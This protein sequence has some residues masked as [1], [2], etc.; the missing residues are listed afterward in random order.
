MNQA[1]G[2]IRL[3]RGYLAGAAVPQLPRGCEAVRERPSAGERLFDPAAYLRFVLRVSGEQDADVEIV[4]DAFGAD[5]VRSQRTRWFVLPVSAQCHR[6][7]STGG[8]LVCVVAHG[9]D[10]FVGE[11]LPHAISVSSRP[12]STGI[13]RE[14]S[15][16]HA[17]QRQGPGG[18]ADGHV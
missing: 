16:R 8:T 9:E 10:R 13:C 12:R 7:R 14:G 18:A 5:V 17:R 15:V 11:S 2:V 1:L 6:D 3:V 4:I